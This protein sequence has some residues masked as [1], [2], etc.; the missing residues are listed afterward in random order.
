VSNSTGEQGTTRGGPRQARLPS[1]TTGVYVKV[2]IGL[3]RQED[4]QRSFWA[5]L[6]PRASVTLVTL[7]S[8]RHFR[9]GRCWPS[10]ASLAQRSGYSRQSISWGLK[11][12]REACLVA[13]RTGGDRL[14]HRNLYEINMAALESPD[15]E[16]IEA[17]RV[18]RAR[19]H[20]VEVISRKRGV[21]HHQVG[22]AKHSADEASYHQ[23]GDASYHQVGDTS[24]HGGTV[25]ITKKTTNKDN[26]S[27][28]GSANAREMLQR[29]LALSQ[30]QGCIND[31]AI[32][33]NWGRDAKRVKDVLTG[34]SANGKTPAEAADLV[35]RLWRT[36][37]SD[38]TFSAAT[39]NVPIFAS[40]IDS[41]AQ[42]KAWVFTPKCKK[43]FAGATGTGSVF[44]EKGDQ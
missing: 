19:I 42:G 31:K 20:K 28:R 2:P 15:S 21:S 43:V 1:K 17:A 13:W 18:A 7:L 16:T 40:H 5:V 26:Q 44:A 38:K 24:L 32:L 11:E 30:E 27:A 35:I 14:G 10:M 8:F 22:D 36:F 9:N 39:K 41:V 37:L 34:Y 4:C 33:V 25:K 12:L 29:M 6:S 23:L 3:F